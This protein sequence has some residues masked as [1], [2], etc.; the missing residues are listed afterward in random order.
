MRLD[1]YLAEQYGDLSRSQLQ[2]YIKAGF[3]KVNGQKIDKPSFDITD[4]DI[5]KFD[6]PAEP[7][8]SG[9]IG[10][11]RKFVIYQD[12]NVIVINKPIGLL[13]HSKGGINHEFTVEDYV[14][15][16]FNPSE[17]AANSGNNRLG[18]VHRL[19]RATSG[20]LICARNLATAS[21]LSRQFAERKAHKT[22]LAVT[23][24]TPYELEAK[25]DLP[26]GRNLNQPSTFR[27]DGKGKA[28][29]TN[30]R[31]IG[32]YP[33]GTSLVEL[34]P[35]TGRTHQLRVHLAYLGCP[36]VG[37]NVYGNGKFGDRLMLHAWQL[38]IS[39]PDGKGGRVRR[40]FIAEP[41]REFNYIEDND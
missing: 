14:R 38:E 21:I 23:S 30:Y 33:D 9:E 6:R 4:N 35:V 32:S 13:V 2:Q 41:P 7:D 18:I 17:L 29:V 1:A 20:I 16:Q 36:I 10:S 40:T 25:I 22:Y 12:D 37:D 26:I 34:K 19:D 3:V 8:F 39:I 27:V 24:K 31:V 28:A 5:V 11:F 15:S